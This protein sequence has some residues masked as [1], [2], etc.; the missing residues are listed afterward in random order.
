V[1]GAE[2]VW[3]GALV[4]QRFT[5]YSRAIRSKRETPSSRNR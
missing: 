2:I 5:W 4:V 1:L 3:I